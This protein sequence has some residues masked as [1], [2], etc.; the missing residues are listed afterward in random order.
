MKTVSLKLPEA[1]DAKV[2]AS[3]RRRRTS[4]SAVIRDALQA[5]LDADGVRSGSALDV[6]RDLAGCVQGPGDLSHNKAHLRT[7]GRR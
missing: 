1:L 3:A 4:K 2:T 6:V 7:Y 5:F